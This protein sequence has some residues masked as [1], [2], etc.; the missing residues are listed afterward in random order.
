MAEYT[1]GATVL[2]RRADADK[3]AAAWGFGM[4]EWQR[5]RLSGHDLGVLKRRMKAAEVAYRDAVYASYSAKAT[6][7]EG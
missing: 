3:T 4:G 6:D 7:G 2:A 5:G 1:P